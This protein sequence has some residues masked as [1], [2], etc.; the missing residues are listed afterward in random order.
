MRTA[1]VTGGNRGLGRATCAGLAAR[2]LRV[3][4]GSRDARHG[5]D[6]AAEL[7]AGGHDVEAVELDVASAASIDACLARL[8]RERRHV[9]VLVNNAGV[10]ALGDVLT[11]GD[12]V[13]REAFAVHVF[14]PLRLCR[15]LVPAM[16]AA[17]WGRVVN[18]SSGLGSFGEEG[19]QE[20]PAAYG[21]S[22]A[23]LNALTVT[24]AAA[25]GPA[26][27]INAVCPG[28]VRTRMGGDQAPRDVEQGADGIVWAATL[29]DDGPSGGFFRDRE[30]LPW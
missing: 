25:A 11:V 10:P 2:G 21:I 3:L 18:V 28:W 9:D 14:G 29:P 5:K 22:K 8:A 15:V 6:V 4:L 7:R 19:L 20:S 24:L 13:F 30:P 12:E 23:A 16:Q 26:V 27:K 1:L 17:G